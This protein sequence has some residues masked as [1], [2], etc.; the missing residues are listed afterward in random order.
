MFYGMSS[1][2]MPPQVVHQPP[3]NMYAEA[4][5]PHHDMHVGMDAGMYGGI[6]P[7]NTPDVNVQSLM[8]NEEVPHPATVVEEQRRNVDQARHNLELKTKEL[9]EKNEQY[10]RGLSEQA[11]Q[12]MQEYQKHLEEQVQQSHQQ[13]DAQVKAKMDGLARTVQEYEY[14]LEGQAVQALERFKAKTIQEAIQKAHEEYKASEVVARAELDEQLRTAQ[15]FAKEGSGHGT[16]E[17]ATRA[18]T[19]YN[20]QLQELQQTMQASIQRASEHV[21][22]AIIGESPAPANIVPP[23]SIGELDAPADLD[24]EQNLDDTN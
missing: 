23:A 19:R 12:Q 20:Q 5:M 17:W 18:Q 16:E 8:P 22:P 3:L 1:Y 24:V 9:I 15:K 14:R 11:T 10:K 13:A 7:Q 21:P 6:L 4:W 2:G